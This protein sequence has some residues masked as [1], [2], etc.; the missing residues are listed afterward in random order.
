MQS[1]DLAGCEDSVG[2]HQLARA[3]GGKRQLRVVKLQRPEGLLIAALYPPS[4]WLLQE[5]LSFGV[6]H[7]QSKGCHPLT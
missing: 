4:C 6:I 3:L 1:V 2:P 5:A 7:V